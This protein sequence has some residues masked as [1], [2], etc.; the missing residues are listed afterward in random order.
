M[1]TET[2]APEFNRDLPNY[3]PC[4]KLLVGQKALVTGASSDIGEAVAIG[5]ARA[6]ADVVVNY[7]TNDEAA[8]KLASEAGIEP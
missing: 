8:R 2:T 4:P 6:G 5:L 3:R 1:V 7:V